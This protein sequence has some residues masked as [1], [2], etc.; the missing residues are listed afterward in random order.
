M[1]ISPNKQGRCYKCKEEFPEG[2]IIFPTVNAKGVLVILCYVCGA[3]RVDV[4]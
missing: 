2:K 1:Y 3:E 4:K